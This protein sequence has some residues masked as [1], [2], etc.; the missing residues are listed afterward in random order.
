MDAGSLP[1]IISEKRKKSIGFSNL[2]GEL[3][4]FIWQ[5]PIFSLLW[6]YNCKHGQK[7]L[8]NLE[9]GIFAAGGIYLEKIFK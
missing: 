7:Y 1:I 3:I 6:N 8:Y 5:V 4:A 9:A 2:G